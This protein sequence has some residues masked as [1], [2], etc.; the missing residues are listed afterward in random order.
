MF[1]N[2]SPLYR[3]HAT[4]VIVDFSDL[5]LN[6]DV[7]TVMNLRPFMEVLLRKTPTSTP[8]PASSPNST[9]PTQSSIVTNR[10]NP[11]GFIDHPV[12]PPQPPTVAI[13]TAKASGTSIGVTGMYVLF[14]VSNVSLD[15]LI[16]SS[17]DIQGIKLGDAFSLQITDL[18]AEIDMLDL[19]KADV[20]LRSLD[21]SDKRD[22]SSDY[23]FR[24]VICA[25]VDMDESLATWRAAAVEETKHLSSSKKLPPKEGITPVG[26]TLT[27]LPDLL[28]LTYEQTSK[29]IS[30][31][32]IILLNMT[33]FVSM[34]AIM[35]LIAVSLANSNAVMAL[36]APSPVTLNSIPLPQCCQTNKDNG[37]DLSVPLPSIPILQKASSNLSSKVHLL[38]DCDQDTLA[39]SMNVTVHVKNPQIILLE[40]PTT[41]ESR[42]IVGSCDIEVHY[43]TT[44]RVIRGNTN[45]KESLH[46]SVRDFDVSV[47]RSMLTRHAQ[48]ILEP[49]GMEYNQRKTSENGR[50][51]SSS[52]SIDIGN[53]TMRVSTKDITLAQ[54][55]MT[56]RVLIEPSTATTGKGTAICNESM[57]EGLSTDV[58]SPSAEL[59]S[60]SSSEDISTFSSSHTISYNMG[61]L[62]LVGINDI[63]GRNLPIIRCTL[64][65]TTFHAE[66]SDQLMTGEGS[67]AISADFYNSRLSV[68][69][70]M[71]DKWKPIL[72]HTS[73]AL[74]SLI[75]IR[76][77]NTLQLTVSGA[78]L[79]RLLKTYSLFFHS[80]DEAERQYV[81]DVLVTNAL[82][83]NIGFDL[84]D[85]ATNTKLMTLNN[86]EVKAVVY[87]QSQ[88][89]HNKIPSLADIAF[90]GEFGEQREPLLQLPFNINRPKICNVH[91]RTDD[92]DDTRGGQQR[93]MSTKFRP[94]VLEPIIEE[95]FENSRYD[96]ITA[97]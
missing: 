14:T 12:T 33:A 38:H 30:V 36:L 52:M 17:S 96:P 24:K 95:V 22:T 15:L 48:P 58:I 59:I 35:D 78:M 94:T 42:A 69:E 50:L 87:L 40:D 4:E 62:S 71:I 76:S 72:S 27:D 51:I 9:N 19:M 3:K 70:P 53:M 13:H 7:N 34:D 75:D 86:G 44:S 41:D 10:D 32:D 46:V 93:I 90:T 68:W 43:S 25:V 83:P 2:L 20:K 49:I 1:S 8:T 65:N 85:S 26:E 45:S 81:P 5:S 57:K 82:G 74:G 88:L 31:V 16:A 54:S 18:R 79:E 91:H 92:G 67:L 66:G 56:R 11:L 39:T 29:E 21:I 80:K 63:N 73:W 64:E 28:Q 47:L 97:R 89:N 6:A 84:Y 61:C 60:S 55:I 23:V 77:V 37:N